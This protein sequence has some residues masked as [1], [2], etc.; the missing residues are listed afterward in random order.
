MNERNNPGADGPFV[1]R[2][3]KLFDESVDRLDGDR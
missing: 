2:A 3:K 1:E